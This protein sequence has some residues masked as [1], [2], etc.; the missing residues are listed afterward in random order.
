MQEEDKLKH[1][2]RN[3]ILCIEHILR[4]IRKCVSEVEKQ[5]ARM[6]RVLREC[7]LSSRLR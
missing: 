6:E 5:L 7:Y 4:E 2:I 1:E 3:A